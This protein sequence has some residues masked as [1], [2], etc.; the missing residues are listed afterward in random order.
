[1]SDTQTHPLIDM[2]QLLECNTLLSA[3]DYY[4]FTDLK[5]ALIDDG[6]PVMQSGFDDTEYDVKIDYTSSHHIWDN[7]ET[8]LEIITTMYGNNALQP[9]IRALNDLSS[10][11]V[12]LSI[13]GGIYS[14]SYHFS[15]LGQW[16][17]DFNGD[18]AALKT[19]YS[20]W[21]TVI[22][23]IDYEHIIKEL[24]QKKAA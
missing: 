16:A 23:N 10:S 19:L 9:L 12:K 11:S 2:L 15:N 14:G 22:G 1:M 7:Q 24:A 4:I 21:K 6:Q 5:Q 13:E 8:I 3:R 17:A 20:D 18:T